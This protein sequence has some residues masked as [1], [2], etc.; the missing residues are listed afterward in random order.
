MTTYTTKPNLLLWGLIVISIG[1][2]IV[3]L[4]HIAGLYRSGVPVYIE[5]DLRNISKPVQRVIPRP[6]NLPDSKV[7]PQEPEP[8]RIQETNLLREEFTLKPTLQNVMPQAAPE[9]IQIPELPEIIGVD[10]A[11]WEEIP[12]K[13]ELQEEKI[14][15]TEEKV[16]LEAAYMDQI[17]QMISAEA[18]RLYQK[19]A[20]K[21]QLQGRT[22]VQIVIGDTGVII[23]EQITESSNHRILDQIA[24]KAVRGASP[25]PKPPTAPM[26]LYIPIN[27]KLI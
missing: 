23:S 17:G 10:I 22:V 9:P 25:F 8:L 12:D 27:F 20:R 14:S 15:G 4:V 16:R 18:G 1:V 21:R 2:H 24:L 19:K 26:S 6:R 13:P 11:A 3:M 7:R 5:L